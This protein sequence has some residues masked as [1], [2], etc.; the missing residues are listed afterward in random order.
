MGIDSR[1]RFKRGDLIRVE[2]PG[3]RSLSG[4][5]MDTRGYTGNSIFTLLIQ[6]TDTEVEFNLNH[7]SVDLLFSADV[8]RGCVNP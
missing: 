5:A 6:G 2:I 4:T 3:G 1:Y 7:C 8:A